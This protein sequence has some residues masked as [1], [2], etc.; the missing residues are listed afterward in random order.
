MSDAIVVSERVEKALFRRAVLL[1]R[2]APQYPRQQGERDAQNDDRH[3]RTHLNMNLSCLHLREQNL[4][5]AVFLRPRLSL[6]TISQDL[7][8]LAQK[9][10]RT[11]GG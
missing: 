6:R 5:R 2:D 7:P 9:N 4:M 8:Q 1:K 11:R 3:E 10:L